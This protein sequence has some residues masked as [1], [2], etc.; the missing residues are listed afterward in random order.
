MTF[1]PGNPDAPGSTWLLSYSAGAA[2]G[3]AGLSKWC[4]GD[5]RVKFKGIREWLG[6]L[7]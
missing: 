5:V 3:G 7:S 2:G 4:A 6:D 1:S